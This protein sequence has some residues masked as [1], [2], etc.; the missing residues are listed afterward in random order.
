MHS[1][2]FLLLTLTALFFLLL[3]LLLITKLIHTKKQLADMADAMEE[4]S[5]GNGNMKLLARQ[6]DLTA[7]LVYRINKIVSGYENRI[8]V[9]KR[10]DEANRQ[11]MTSLSHDVRT[12][13]TTLIGYLDAIHR[14]IVTGDERASYFET[15]RKKALDLKDYIDVLFDWFKLNSDELAITMVP[16]EATEF[17]RNILKDW[18]PVFEENDIEYDIEFPECP[19]KI[20]IDQNGYTRIVNNLI[21][22]V[23]THS[24]ATYI[25]ITMSMQ[26]NTIRL[27]VADNGIGISREDIPHIFD[28]LY[29]CDKGRSEKGSGLGLAITQQ[30]VE[31]MNGTIEADS[32][33]GEKTIFTV[34]FPLA[35]RQTPRF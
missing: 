6:S 4:I 3:S 14:G 30:M 28:R 16:V 33:P 27:C 17:T 20:K 19:C 11:L 34:Q 26:N 21:Q 32:I 13:L 12:P 31:K 15:A 29:K 2:L 10:V 24:R 23:I 18:I 22:N 35:L 9:M 7:P 25:K 5:N 8:I 1:N